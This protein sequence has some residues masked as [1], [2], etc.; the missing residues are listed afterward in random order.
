[1]KRWRLTRKARTDL[2]DIW[3]YTADL[4][5]IAQAERYIRQIEMELTAASQGKALARPIDAYWRV[6]SGHHFCIFRKLPDGEIEVIR[7]LH[8]RMD[9]D[10]HL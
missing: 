1:M 4:W 9:I 6:K 10:R 8:E 2:A 7:I 5:G 3:N